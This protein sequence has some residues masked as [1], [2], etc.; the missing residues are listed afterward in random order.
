MQSQI[1]LAD[2]KHSEPQAQGPQNPGM[3]P[4][5]RVTRANG[6]KLGKVGEEFTVGQP[7]CFPWPGSDL[8]CAIRALL[9]CTS[10]CW[11]LDNQLALRTVHCEFVV[12][13]IRVYKTF[14]CVGPQALARQHV[15]AHI[16]QDSALSEG[17]Q[18]YSSPRGLKTLILSKSRIDKANLSSRTYPKI[19][20][21]PCVKT[22]I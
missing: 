2:Y 20:C 12:K 8:H 9:L 6:Y 22:G 11:C 10:A 4:I 16:A 15:I 17:I 7:G 18:L 21:H 1:T 3:H 5:V 13:Y 19:A 14:W